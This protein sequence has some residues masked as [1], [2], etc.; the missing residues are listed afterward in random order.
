MQHEGGTLVPSFQLDEAGEV[1]SEL[2]AVLEPLLAAGTDPWLVWTWLTTP[3][4][5]LGGRVP[6]EAAR[7]AEELPLVQHAAVRLAER[8]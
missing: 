3:A 2:V 7:D 8:R 5:L 6:H 4:G 1:R